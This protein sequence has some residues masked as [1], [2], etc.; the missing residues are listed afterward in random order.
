LP[1]KSLNV[2]AAN[3]FNSR[4]Q[5][6]RTAPSIACDPERVEFQGGFFDPFRVGGLFSLVP[7][8][9]P[10]A[11]QFNRFAV[12]SFCAKRRC[13]AAGNAR[14]LGRPIQLFKSVCAQSAAQL[15]PLIHKRSAMSART[16]AWKPDTRLVPLRD[17]A[18]EPR[19][20]L[21]PARMLRRKEV[22][23]RR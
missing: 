3:N 14:S 22:R 9:L 20:R 16:R 10:T 17:R 2:R 21:L 4:W 18:M 8:A 6:H 12:I 23:R 5:R 1:K 11:I 13:E 15:L 7:W 19:L